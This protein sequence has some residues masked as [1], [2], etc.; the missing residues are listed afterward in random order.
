MCKTIADIIITVVLRRYGLIAISAWIYNGINI[1][2]IIN[3]VILV[4]DYDTMTLYVL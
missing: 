1:D 3:A 2:T 4:D